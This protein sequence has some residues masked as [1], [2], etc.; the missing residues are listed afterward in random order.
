MKK[1]LQ[2]SAYALGLLIFVVSGL[3]VLMSYNQARAFV[4][5]FRGPTYV[6]PSDYGLEFEAVTLTCEDGLKIA[7]WYIPTRNRAV[8][9][10]ESGIYGTRAHMLD[11]AAMLARHGYGLMV[12]DARTRGLSEGDTFTFGK[13]EVRDIEAAYRYLVGRSDVDAQRIG[14]LGDSMGGVVMLLHAAQNKGIKAVVADSPFASLEDEIETGVKKFTGLPPFPFAPL[15]QWFS[16]RQN[17]VHR[18]EVAPIRVI[19]SISPRPVF[20]MQGGKDTVI[21]PNSGQRLYDAAGEP[22]QL[23]FEPELEHIEFWW[24]RP[25]EYEKRVVAFF[26]QHLLGQ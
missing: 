17:G 5:P 21:P 12:V 8:V 9:I 7:A 20:L 25:K 19:R 22:R 10:L 2:R 18:G 26:D 16:E 15:I 14:A 6:S 4:A 1:W 13:H 11:R 23:W 3:V 24:A